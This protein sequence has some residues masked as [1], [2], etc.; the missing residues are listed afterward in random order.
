MSLRSKVGHGTALF[1]GIAYGAGMM[2]LLDPDRGNARRALIRDRMIHLR[3]EARWWFSRQMRDLVHRG[4][5]AVAEARSRVVEKPVSD[6][7]LQERVRAQI[8]HVVSHPGMLE[9]KCRNGHVTLHGVV[10]PG[11]QGKIEKRLGST[12]GVRAWSLELREQQDIDA[13][14][15]GQSQF[16]R[17]VG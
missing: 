8:G 9:V 10:I 16:Q 17:R 12:R 14:A 11:E 1:V 7:V 13:A 15:G 5:G 2:Y 6:D 3:N 4:Q